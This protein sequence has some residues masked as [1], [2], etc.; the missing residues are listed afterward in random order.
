MSYHEF[1]LNLTA[2]QKSKLAACVKTKSPVTLRLSVDQL[3]GSDKVML[4][5][6]QIARIMKREKM[7]T[8]IDLRFSSA[9]LKKQTGGW[10]GSLLATLAGSL[11]R[12]LLGRGIKNRGRGLFCREQIHKTF[13]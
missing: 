10:I 9:Q 6:Q 12:S 2:N 7:N 11:L 3:H 4:T 5:N 8:G 13:V 1:G